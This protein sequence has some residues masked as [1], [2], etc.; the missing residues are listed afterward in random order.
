MKVGKPFSGRKNSGT[1]RDAYLQER[2]GERAV[3]KDGRKEAL[4]IKGKRK[5]GEK[6]GRDG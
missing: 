3:E 5:W 4:D 1:N 2:K 6:Q